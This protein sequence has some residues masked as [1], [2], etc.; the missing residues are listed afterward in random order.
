[1]VE[2]GGDRLAW[3]ARSQTGSEFGCSRRA[4]LVEPQQTGWHSWQS[5]GWHSS[6]ADIEGSEYTRLSCG[7][8]DRLPWLARCRGDWQSGGGKGGPE[9]GDLAPSRSTVAGGKA[10]A[11]VY[12]R[13]RCVAFVYKSI[14]LNAHVCSVYLT[15]WKG[16]PHHCTPGVY[17]LKQALCFLRASEPTCLVARRR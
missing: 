11:S 13:L 5:G 16:S 7:G 2:S 9:Q 3:L 6:E 1:M 10:S 8:P 4:I 15:S 17:P 12:V 14:F